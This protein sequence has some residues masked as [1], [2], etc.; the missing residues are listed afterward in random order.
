MQ[1]IQEKRFYYQRPICIQQHHRDENSLATKG[2]A[3]FPE[4]TET[5]EINPDSD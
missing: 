5:D 2:T 4:E 3:E 1:T